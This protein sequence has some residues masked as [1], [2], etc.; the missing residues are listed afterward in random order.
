VSRKNIAIAVFALWVIG[1]ALFTHRQISRSPRERMIEAAVR[2]APGT[3][4]Y[5]VTLNGVPIGAAMSGVDTTKS[6]I[7]TSDYFEGLYPVGKDTFEIIARSNATYS[8]G[9]GL[10]EIGVAL[11]GNVTHVTMAGQMIGDSVLLLTMKTGD[12]HPQSMRFTSATPVFTPTMAPIVGMLSRDR[13]EGDTIN[14]SIFDPVARE[15]NP[16]V[17][18]VGKD[19]LFTVIDS[20][21]LDRKINDWIPGSTDTVRGR[22]LG[23]HGAPMTVW[24]D[25]EGRIVAASEPGGMQM[26]RTAYDIAF[27]RRSRAASVARASAPVSATKRK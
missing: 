25:K 23:G 21:I 17:I 9:L 18:R 24:V 7:I 10:S 14:I 15:V 8:R 4:F 12:A 1:I 27:H 20:A 22:M 16:A 2:V 3:Y 26:I 13:S 6:R 11:E 19:S 5:L